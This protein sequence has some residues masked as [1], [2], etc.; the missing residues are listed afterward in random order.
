[1]TIEE[2]IR[3][4]KEEIKKANRELS[5]LQDE[6]RARNEPMKIDV[7]CVSVSRDSQ[8]VSLSCGG[9]PLFNND[10]QVVAKV[11]CNKYPNPEKIRLAIESLSEKNDEPK[12]YVDWKWVD[13][14]IIRHGCMPGEYNYCTIDKNNT[15]CVHRRKPEVI[16]GSMWFGADGG[17]LSIG[18]YGSND[19]PWDK[20]LI[21]RPGIKE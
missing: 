7:V 18:I 6:A 2:K 9:G 13:A 11:K 14:E 10:Y 20:S 8:Y 19:I 3:A 21:H 17:R 16:Y 1:M 5:K 12:S 4:K 15:I